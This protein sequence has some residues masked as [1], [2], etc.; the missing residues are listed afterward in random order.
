MSQGDDYD[1][2]LCSEARRAIAWQALKETR[3]PEYVAMRYNFPVSKMRDAL[4]KI[5]DE[6]PLYRVLE[7]RKPSAKRGVPRTA[8]S[9]L[10]ET[11]LGAGLANREADE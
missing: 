6:K 5:P 3:N 10:S 8:K 9:L 1:K 2:F 7:D 11:G 4:A